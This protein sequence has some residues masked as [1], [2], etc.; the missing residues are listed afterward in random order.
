MGEALEH[1]SLIEG[2]QL[3]PHHTV[4]PQAGSVEVYK[5]LRPSKRRLGWRRQGG[6]YVGK[7]QAPL[8]A[9]SRA[10]AWASA[11]WAL[12]LSGLVGWP[13]NAAAACWAAS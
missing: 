1:Q 9:C 3:Q 13:S 7:G 12:T 5:R 6:G 10:R 2:E 4:L 8:L 11:C